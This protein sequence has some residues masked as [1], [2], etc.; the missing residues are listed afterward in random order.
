MFYTL[1]YF[2]T[3]LSITSNIHSFLAIMLVALP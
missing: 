3:I 2:Y 1:S